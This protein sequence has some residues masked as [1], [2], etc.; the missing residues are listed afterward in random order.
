MS[1]L[2]RAL[3]LAALVLVLCQ[4]TSCDPGTVFDWLCGAGLTLWAGGGWLARYQR[5]RAR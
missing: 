3:L 5:T 4:V 1:A 2:G